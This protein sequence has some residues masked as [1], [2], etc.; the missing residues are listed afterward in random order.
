MM[1]KILLAYGIPEKIVSFISFE[2]FKIELFNIVTGGLQGDT[3]APLLF[4]IPLDYVM[5]Q[6]IQR[7]EELGF[8]ITLLKNRRVPPAILTDLS[9][10]DNVALNSELNRPKNFEKG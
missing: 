1:L 8:E 4:I 6:A 10:A 2:L 7:N 3:L 9:F 5:R